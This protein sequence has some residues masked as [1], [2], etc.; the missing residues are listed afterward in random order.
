MA[1]FSGKN[2]IVWS[3]FFLTLLVILMLQVGQ[4]LLT[5]NYYDHRLNTWQAPFHHIYVRFGLR[6]LVIYTNVFIAFQQFKRMGVA[7]FIPRFFV[8][9]SVALD[10]IF[11]LAGGL[12]LIFPDNAFLLAKYGESFG[13][14]NSGILYVFCFGLHF[15]MNGTQKRI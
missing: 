14:I 6:E 8:F 11:I 1:D 7:P 12:R 9:S 13:Y 3:R 5:Y 4:E 10:L 2:S 15:V